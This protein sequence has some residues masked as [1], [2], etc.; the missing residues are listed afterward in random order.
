MKQIVDAVK[1]HRLGEVRE[2]FEEYAANLGIS[3][4]FQNF[5]EELAGLPGR[6]AAPGGVILLADVEGVA[7][8]C[9]ALR[10]LEEA[11]L[12]EMKRLYVRERFREMRLGR[13][14]AEAVIEKAR[15]ADYRAMRLDTLPSMGRAIGL[16]E[17]LGFTD[18]APYCKNPHEGV[19]YLELKLK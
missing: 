10:P 17:K 5:D 11:G 4:C 13:A 18:I 9:V 2:L 1:S 12:C 14:L 3:L 6:Y 19:R 8:G 7:A 15:Q 16:Y